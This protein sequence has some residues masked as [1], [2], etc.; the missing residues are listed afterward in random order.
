MGEYRVN[1]EMY[2][3]PLDLLLY[4]IRRDEIDIHNIPIARITEQYCAYVDTLRQIDPDV[5]GE[6]LVVA[7]MLLEI[8]TRMLLP[9]P[10]AHA[11]GEEAFD[12]RAELVRQL[13]EYK[14]FK[15]AAGDLRAA[16]EEQSLRFP[17]RPGEAEEEGKE[18]QMDLEEVQV[19]DLVDA[20]NR[21]MA[22]IGQTA[23][24]AQIIYDDTPIELHAEDILDRL[25]TE[26]NLTFRD[27]FAGRTG[28]S[29]MIG[30]F[31]A[32]LELARRR[33]IYLEQDRAFGDIRLYL[34]PTPPANADRPE[35]GTYAPQTPPEKDAAEGRGGIG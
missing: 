10:E 6:F 31:L 29:E 4:L 24:E 34:H 35:V 7:T 9:G 17:R 3:G 20:F 19:W 21:V 18:P 1:L 2:N 33:A 8:K 32:M 27:V 25:R 12:P 13:L 23:R 11:G 5:A 15:D 26:G 16:A 28:R 22:S 14:A 30:L